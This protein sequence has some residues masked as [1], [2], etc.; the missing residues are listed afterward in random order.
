M[1]TLLLLLL[2]LRWLLCYGD[3]IRNVLCTHTLECVCSLRGL[4]QVSV[5]CGYCSRHFG[6]DRAPGVAL[7]GCVPML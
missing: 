2:L 4:P 1:I 6:L 5:R 7:S 3:D